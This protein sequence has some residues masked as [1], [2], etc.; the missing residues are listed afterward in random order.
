MIA[1][2]HLFSFAGL[3][4]ECRNRIEKFYGAIVSK[5]IQ[6]INMNAE[7]GMRKRETMIYECGVRNAEAGNNYE[8]GQNVH[9][10]PD[11]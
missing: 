3:K 6:K 10:G 2:H 4:D 11:G 5:K 9:R 1:L 7:F 8:R